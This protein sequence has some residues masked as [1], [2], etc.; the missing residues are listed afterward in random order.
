MLIGI[1][2][3]DHRIPEIPTGPGATGLRRFNAAILFEPNR[4]ALGFYHKMHLVPFGEYFPLIETLPWLRA[5]TPF[6]N[7]KPQ[8]LNFG[9]API[10]LPLGPYRLA[11]SICF[12]DTIPHVIRRSFAD[13]DPA[14]QPDV[15]L[16]LSNDGW[17]HGSAELDMHLASGV[18]RCIE[19]RV[20][21]ARAVNTGLS[22]LVDGNGEIRDSLPKETNGVLTVTVPLDKRTSYYSRWGDWLGLSCLAISIGLVP[23]GVIRRERP[24]GQPKKLTES[25]ELPNPS[26]LP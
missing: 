21:L 7:E 15:L 12:E 1:I 13:A 22:A 9:E 17:F 16:N 19:N 6:R 2:R 8:S 5:L 25:P 26:R 11:V 4:Q 18:F 23:L 24:S 10:S 14:A 3:Y 20:P